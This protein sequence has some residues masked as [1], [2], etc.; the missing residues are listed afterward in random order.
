MCNVVIMKFDQARPHRGGGRRREHGMLFGPDRRGR[1][2]TSAAD[3]EEITS[4]FAGNLID[5]WFVGQ[6]TFT[7][8]DYEVLVVGEVSAPELSEETNRAIAERARIERF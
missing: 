4:W 3:R 6:P 1:S 8:D 7:V 2:T 5:N